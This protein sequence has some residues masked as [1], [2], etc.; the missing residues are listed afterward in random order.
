MAFEYSDQN[1]FDA[2]DNNDVDALKKEIDKH[3]KAFGRIDPNLI[4]NGRNLIYAAAEQENEEIF[5]LL[6]QNGANINFYALEEAVKQNSISVVKFLLSHGADVNVKDRF[7]WT[8]LHEVSRRHDRFEITK[9]LLEYGA[10]VNVRT[11][12]GITPLCFATAF[13]VVATINLLLSHNANPNVGDNNNLTPLHVAAI[14]NNIEAIKILL[15]HGADVNVKDYIHKQT[16]KEMAE[17]FKENH[18]A[19]KILSTPIFTS[20]SFNQ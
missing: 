9:L 14:H 13:N 17:L 6:I 11:K 15:S 10:D 4:I 1:F 3:T 19:A 16:P 8:P 12:E 18:E 5:N 20:E 2:I 7:G